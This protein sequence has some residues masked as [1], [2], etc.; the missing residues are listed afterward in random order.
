MNLYSYG[1]DDIIIAGKIDHQESFLV[2]VKYYKDHLEEDEIFLGGI[3]EE[4][5]ILE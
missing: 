1:N 3:L 4:M 5:V 2:S